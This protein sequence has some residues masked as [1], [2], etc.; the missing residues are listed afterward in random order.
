MGK[1]IDRTLTLR[2]IDPDGAPIDRVCDQVHAAWFRIA[3]PAISFVVFHVVVVR[4]AKVCF[5]VILRSAFSGTEGSNSAESVWSL[6][7]GSAVKP[8]GRPDA[9]N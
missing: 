7:R 8:V 6:V 2:P 5:I 4:P 9:R 1:R 3:A